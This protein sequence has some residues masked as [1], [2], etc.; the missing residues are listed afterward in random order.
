MHFKCSILMA[1]FDSIINH[2]Y[3]V[4]AVEQTDKISE[5]YTPIW[6]LHISTLILSSHISD[7]PR[8]LGIADTICTVVYIRQQ[9]NNL[10]NCK[11]CRN[12]A[13]CWYPWNHFSLHQ[14]QLSAVSS[15]TSTALS[16]S[17]SFGF[18]V[19]VQH[20]TQKKWNISMRT[21]YF[22]TMKLLWF[23]T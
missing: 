10:I 2:L 15:Q 21:T 7:L 13:V 1:F 18:T 16:S 19:S 5:A 9:P 14:D 6:E 12:A 11:Y 3:S 22:N 8:H 4:Q 20:W 23:C 17:L